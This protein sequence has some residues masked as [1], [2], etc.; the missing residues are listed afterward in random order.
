MKITNIPHID[1]ESLCYKY[2][3]LGDSNYSTWAVYRDSVL[4]YYLDSDE[5]GVINSVIKACEGV[6]ER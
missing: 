5:A 4:L 3:Q 6:Y 2:I 1:D